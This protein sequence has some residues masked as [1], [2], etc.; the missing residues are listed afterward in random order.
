MER[1]TDKNMSESQI[2]EIVELMS[3]E[4]AEALKLWG[5][6]NYNQGV[7]CGMITGPILAIVVGFGAVVSVRAAKAT[8]DLGKAFIEM[9]KDYSQG[10]GPASK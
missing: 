10:S 6:R 2:T 9:I 7:G 5:E 3:G 4:H 8:W 1:F